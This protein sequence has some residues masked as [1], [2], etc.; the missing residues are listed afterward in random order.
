M[1]VSESSQISI[2]KLA[3]RV[4]V[5]VGTIRRWCREGKLKETSRTPGNHRRFAYDDFKHILPAEDSLRKVVVYARGSSHDQKSD[6]ETQAQRLRDHG[7]DEVITDLG[8][9]L[10]CRKP[11]LRKFLL[12]ILLNQVSTLVLTHED[13]L[14]RFGTE[15]VFLLCRRQSV[16]INILEEPA[17]TPLEEELVKEVIT[18]MTVFSA[19]LYGKRSWKNRN[20]LAS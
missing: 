7:C 11:G 9:G 3:L 20:R 10:N 17:E 2:G 1:K 8:S 18:L 5:C 4:G 15:I 14:L 19:R 12:M 6:L 16:H 13:R